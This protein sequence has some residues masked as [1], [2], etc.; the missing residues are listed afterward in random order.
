MNYII[1][2]LLC[3]ISVGALV[4]IMAYVGAETEKDCNKIGGHIVSLYKSEICVSKNG[5]ILE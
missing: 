5:R 2:I 1:C 4:T 3:V